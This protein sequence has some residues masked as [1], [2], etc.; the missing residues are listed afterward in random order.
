MLSKAA[1]GSPATLGSEGLEILS[2]PLEGFGGTKGGS[3][4]FFPAPGTAGLESATFV[5]ALAAVAV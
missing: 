5:P 4:K 3:V 2:G 1:K